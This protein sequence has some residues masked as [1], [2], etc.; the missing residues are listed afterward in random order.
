MPGFPSCPCRIF[1]LL[2]SWLA[3]DLCVQ[4]DP[5][6]LPKLGN[7]GAG[8]CALHG[9]AQGCGDCPQQVAFAISLDGNHVGTL[10]PSQIR[11]D[12]I[13]PAVLPGTD[14]LLKLKN[15]PRLFQ[16]LNCAIDPAEESLPG[17]HQRIRGC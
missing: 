8:G 1:A 9:R 4:I 5:S 3:S 11:F 16:V 2:A 7:E 17:I 12:D 13:F 14:E 6:V 15:G 10:A